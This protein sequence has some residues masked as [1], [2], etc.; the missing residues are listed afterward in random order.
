MSPT[1]EL[2][3][4]LIARPSLTPDDAGCQKLIA[5]RLAKSN[6]KIEHMRFGE[7]D[8]LWARYGTQ[9]PLLVF[10]GHTDVVP[11]GPL[12]AWKKDPFTPDIRG[13]YLYGRGA[14][15][16]KSGLSAMIVAAE[17]FIRKN[18][19]FPGSIALLITSDEEGPSIDG[20][21][22]VVEKLVARKE[23]IDYCIV[24]EASSDKTLGDQ[25]R[26]GRRGS[27]H[28]TLT[29]H[30]KLG[31]VAYPE[32]GDNPIHKCAPALAAL[33][34]EKW[35]AGNEFFPPTTFQI[36]N[37]HSG[38]GAANVI[39]G[40]LEARFN[41][42]FCTASTQKDLEARV[43]KILDAHALKYTLTWD[44]S[45]NPFLTSQG[46]LVKAAQAVIKE[47]AGIDPILSTGGGTSDGRFIAPTGA[48]VI[49]M[50]PINATIHQVDECVLISDLDKLTAMYEKV[51]EKLFF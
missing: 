6:F 36:S 19:D 49:E 2:T 45:G 18:P 30:G 51:L 12:D 44:L 16:M 4:T 37:I 3:K 29:V 27:L 21:Q 47:L 24:G 41:F 7:V 23:K 1:L 15:D 38:T 31:H 17:N 28:G 25:I 32:L 5:E 39:P 46:K 9:T 40:S 14:A 13:D 20:T 43:K 34:Q 48:E 22:K 26:V 10:A 50:G 35:D 11:T 33:A 42:R 8:N